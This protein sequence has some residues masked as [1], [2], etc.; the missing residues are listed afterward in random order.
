MGTTQTALQNDPSYVGKMSVKAIGCVPANLPVDG[1][2]KLLCQFYGKCTGVKIGV[3]K[4]QD[5]TWRALVGTFAG[6]N[7]E[8][9]EQF[10]SGKLFLPDGIQEIIETGITQLGENKE[11]LSIRFALELYSVSA[12]NPAGYSY[13]AKNL[14]PVESTDE[15]SEI[16]K[17]IAQARNDRPQLTAVSSQAESDAKSQT[18]TKKK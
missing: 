2:A 8:T 15:M 18:I 1:S 6:I 14:L 13:K 17:A 7:F 3:D 12:K 10:R 11:G 16:Q 9:G 5:R 4:I